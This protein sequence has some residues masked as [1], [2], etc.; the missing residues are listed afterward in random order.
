MEKLKKY[1]KALLEILKYYASVKSPFMLDVDNKVISDTKNHHYQLQRIGWHQ[2]SHVH[3]TVFHFE[4]R[5]NKVWVHENR[6]DVNID[7]KLIE[8]GIDAKDIM[9]GL[10]QPIAITMGQSAT[11]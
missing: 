3:Y 11:A 4:I 7:A 6:T 1:Q 9:S 8:S 10:D 5:N 2:N